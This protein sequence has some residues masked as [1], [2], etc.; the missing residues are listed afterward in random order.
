[1]VFLFV[2]IVFFGS[3]DKEPA[4]AMIEAPSAEACAA[5]ATDLKAH[6]EADT[7]VQGYVI[8]CRKVPTKL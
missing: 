8:E 6:A 1:M 7:E 4:S 5:K 3:T 2:L